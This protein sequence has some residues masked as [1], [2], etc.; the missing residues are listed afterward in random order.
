MSI[1]FSAWPVKSNPLGIKFL[2][3]AIDQFVAVCTQ[4]KYFKNI[5]KILLKP[6]KAI[7]INTCDPNI[8][9]ND[10]HIIL[11]GATI[12]IIGLRTPKKA[13]NI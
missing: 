5:Y 10:L 3:N 4:Q 8:K 12:L 11:A 13:E 2:R 6:G 7:F 9:I 1:Y